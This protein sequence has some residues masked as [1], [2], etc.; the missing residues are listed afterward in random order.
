[1]IHHETMNQH[2]MNITILVDF[3]PILKVLFSV[4]QAAGMSVLVL[5]RSSPPTCEQGGLTEGQQLGDGGVLL[6][7]VQRG[8]VGPPEAWGLEGR[9]SMERTMKTVFTL[10]HRTMSGMEDLQ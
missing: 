10:H 5:I 6:A 9:E 7:A 3:R 4:V 8:A 2:I 1:M